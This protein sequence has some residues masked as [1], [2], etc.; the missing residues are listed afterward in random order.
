[1]NV[2]GSDRPERY[3]GAY[4]SA[5]AFRLLRVQP[6]L[7][8]T[9]REGEDAPGSPAVVVLSDELWRNRFGADRGI[10]GKTIRVNGEQAE[11]IGVMGPGFSFPANEV[12]WVPLRDAPEAKRVDARQYGVFGRLKEGVSIDQ[13]N[14]E[15]SGIAKRLASAYPESNRDI[16]AAVKPYTESFIGKE[17]RMMLFTMLFAVF[18]VLLIAC[19]NVANLLL[20]QAAQRAKEVGV[21]TA[22]GASRGRIMM[23]FLTEPLVM[24]AAGAVLGV[25]LAALGIKLF[26]DAIA[27]TQP[28]FFIVIRLDAPIL[29]FVLAIT[30]FA[31]LVSGVLP[32]LRASGA[33]VNEVLKD[34]ARGSSSFRGG[35][36][37]KALVVFEIALSVGLLVAAGLTTKSVTQLAR[38]DFGVPTRD[39]FTARI[40]LPEAQYADSAAQ[41]RFFNQLFPRLAEVPGVQA[42][43][44]TSHMPVLGS[45][46]GPVAIDGKA[47]ATERD[48]PEA[49]SISTFPGY[50]NTF[51]VAVK[52]RDFGT[53]DT[54][55]SQPVAIVNQAFATKFFGRDD[56]V[57]RRIRFGGA[58]STEPWRT[59]VGVVPD[60]WT[61]GTDNEDPEAAYVPY[62]QAPQRYMSVA[63]RTT[64]EPGSLTAPVRDLVASLDPDLPIYFVKTLQG[65]IDEN[66]WFYR[67]FGVIFMIMGVVALFLAAIGL[68]GV[69]AFS[70]SRRTREMG[71]RMALGAQPR[72]VIRLVLNQGLAQ[73]AIGLTMGIGL[74][75]L[76]AKGLEAILFQ[77]KAIDPLVYLSTVVVLA[78]SAIAASLVPARRATRVDPMVALRY[79]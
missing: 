50:F 64:R 10:V 28:P 20:G 39:V 27:S 65:R 45:N 70:V 22:L 15:L 9:F 46:Q 69:M 32:A 31:A 4:L 47:Y 42:Y 37:S 16:G 63:I 11:V 49:G 51:N 8:R 17:P 61:D 5:N 24:A 44:I 77:V 36:L 14:V 67:V 57:G 73:L 75:Y 56:P 68:Y 43:T 76:L 55:T 78:A 72:D 52:G 59:I 62:A 2:S 35:R 12:L 79:E 25:G 33:N 40:G 54:E 38:K 60:L 6:A 41:V 66:T 21:R 19:A 23:Q 58:R 3:D 1:F 53:Q 48:Y 71:V 74:A 34:E 7:G 29:L 13:A 26:N 18:L 30:L